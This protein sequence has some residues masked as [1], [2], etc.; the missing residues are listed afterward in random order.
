[1]AAGP[2]LREFQLIERVRRRFGQTDPSVV[3]GIGDDT[4]IMKLPPGRH[5]LLTT[6]L[7]VENIHF[8]LRTTSLEDVGY[9]A[10][11][12]N[13]SDIAAMGGVPHAL[14]VSIAVPPSANVADMDRLYRGL[15]AACRPH[16]VSLVGGD[17]SA[18]RNG[19]FLSIALTGYVAPMHALRRDGARVGDLVYATGTLGDSLAGL[20]LL[21]ARHKTGINGRD[22]RYLIARHRRPT[23]RIQTGQFLVARRLATSAIDISDGLSGDLRHICEQSGVGAEIDAAALPLSRASRAYAAAT[24]TDPIQLALCGGEDYELL[25]TVPA[26]KCAALDRFRRHAGCRLTPIGIIRLKR[27]GITL[28]TVRGNVIPLRNTSYQHFAPNR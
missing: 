17:T 15:M 21:Q 6:D 10:A 19:L 26:R 8:D 24:K 27:Y 14:A 3:L 5:L 1:M 13:L 4:A 23:P 2:R 22:I 28:K 18:S 25:F 9:K 20:R 12:A 16:Q 11:V 7:L